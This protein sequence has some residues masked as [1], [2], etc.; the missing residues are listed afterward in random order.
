MTV[1]R[2]GHVTRAVLLELL[3]EA[4]AEAL[5]ESPLSVPCIDKTAPK[6]RALWWISEDRAENAAAAK[7]CRACPVLASCREAGRAQLS[8][9]W[10]G[11]LRRQFTTDDGDA[12][13]CS[14]SQG[15]PARMACATPTSR[16]SS[17]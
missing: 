4:V 16:D 13:V 12:E 14:A 15:Q 11:H 7:L 17:G 3:Y 10:G 6:D 9:V 8:G 2:D 5:A 1:T